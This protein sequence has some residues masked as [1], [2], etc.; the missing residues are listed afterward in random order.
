M[1]RNSVIYLSLSKKFTHLF[2]VLFDKMVNE[3][4][5]TFQTQFL[6]RS[7]VCVIIFSRPSLSAA[8]SIRFLPIA[9]LPCIFNMSGVWFRMKYGIYMN[10]IRYHRLTFSGAISHQICVLHHVPQTRRWDHIGWAKL[11][12]KW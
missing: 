10:G 1:R 12:W 4:I 5:R 3:P 7:F 11:K 6:K 8:I 2:L 9:I